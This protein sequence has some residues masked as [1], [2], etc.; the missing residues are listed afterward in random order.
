MV[1]CL[2]STPLPLGQ[3]DLGGNTTDVI[4]GGADL[5]GEDAGLDIDGLR[6]KAP[7]GFERDALDI[8]LK[9]KFRVQYLRK[10]SDEKVWVPK[11]LR[12]PK[13]QSVIIFDWDDTLMYTSFLAQAQNRAIPPATKR[14]LLRIESASL[15]L[16]ET[17]LGLGHT[18]IITNAQEGWVEESAAC[19]MPTLAPILKRVRIISARTSHEAEASGDVA[20]WKKLAFLELGRQLPPQPITNLVST[21]D[22]NFELEAAHLLGEQ[23]ARS[24]IKT[25]KLQERPSPQELVKELELLLPK[26]QSIV[27]KASNMKIRLERRPV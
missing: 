23:F 4:L 17:A 18:F 1:T 20:L 2:P 14:H 24:L 27:E 16:L 13:H 25:V 6:E 9:D 21:G 11:E 10:L 7:Q 8:A 19:Y 12:P 5:H 3:E 15:K 26:F 22:S